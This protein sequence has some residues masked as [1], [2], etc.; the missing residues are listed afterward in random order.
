MNQNTTD[1]KQAE[2]LE[3]ILPETPNI[4]RCFK[5]GMFRLVFRE[6]ENLL[7]LYNAISG[8]RSKTV[9]R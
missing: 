1:Q 5:D 4:N 9:R 7:S 6:K 2:Y 3:S 8:Y